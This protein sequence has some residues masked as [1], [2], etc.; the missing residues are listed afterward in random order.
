[1]VIRPPLELDLGEDIVF[2]EFSPIALDA[3]IE[4]VTYVWGGTTGQTGTDRT[5]TPEDLGTYW[6]TIED[7]LACT[8]RDTISVIETTEQIEASFLIPS[9]VVVGDLIYLIP[10][11]E[12]V[13]DSYLW[14][15]GDGTTS[16]LQNPTKQYSIP[17]SY[18]ITLTVSNGT[19]EH[20][21]RKTI[22]V[23][24][25]GGRFDG[26]ESQVARFV[27]IVE[28]V[29]YPNPVN[30]RLKV[31]VLLTEESKTYVRI[32]DA[33]ER[34]SFDISICCMKANWNLI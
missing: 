8:D 23:E 33:Q 22:N 25:A 31:K 12:P 21:I 28:T 1:M 13:A 2:C 4:N 3:H 5:F 7:D 19:C 17:G 16:T 29:L 26:P 24:P 32:F 10:L 18:E 30:E 14:E 11:T 6:V 27:D 9:E 34:R 15:Y 20:S